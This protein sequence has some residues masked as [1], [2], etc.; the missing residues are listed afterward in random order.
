MQVMA[1]PKAKQPKR[2]PGRPKG[3]EPARRS[4]LS[5]RATEQWRD[6]INGLAD[7]VDMPATVMID[8]ALKLYA[9]SVG[10]GD[11]FPGR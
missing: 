1:R 2:G 8:Q 5:I 3:E 10:F 11:E 9:K 6:W 4:M 7:H